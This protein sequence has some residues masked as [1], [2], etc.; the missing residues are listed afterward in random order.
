MNDQDGNS[1]KT[2]IVGI[3]NTPL[4]AKE[5]MAENLKASHFANG[6]PIALVSNNNIWEFSTT[7]AS[8]WYGND[9]INYNCPHGKLYNWYAVSD[10]RNICPAGWH[11]PSDEE[12]SLFISFYDP[13]SN[14]SISPESQTVGGKMKSKGTLYWSSPNVGANNTSGFSGLPGGFRYFDGSF[15]FFGETGYWWS[16]TSN[17]VSEAFNRNINVGSSVVGRA[18][19]GDDKRN[20]F[21]VRCVRN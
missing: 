12:W 9:S 7:A 5:W 2:V 1:Y 21:S 4:G 16:S 14:P 20:G 3:Y 18:T 11:V 15:N 13:A 6:D 17:G 10:S 19:N 8:C